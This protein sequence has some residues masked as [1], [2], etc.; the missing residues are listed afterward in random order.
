MAAGACG[1]RATEKTATGTHGREVER[2]AGLAP[3]SR[4]PAH[5]SVVAREQPFVGLSFQRGLLL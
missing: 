5:S 3:D 1:V 2:S 4:G